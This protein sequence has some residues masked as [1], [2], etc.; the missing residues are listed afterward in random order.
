MPSGDAAWRD[1]GR[2]S[3]SRSPAGR[4]L[5]VAPQLDL[6]AGLLAMIAAVLAVRPVRRHQALADGMGALGWSIGHRAPPL[7]GTLR[8]APP[9]FNPGCQL[10]S[11]SDFCVPVYS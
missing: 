11:A 8:L 3:R 7:M 4:V 1:G 10:L 5:T 6:I 2:S 9:Q